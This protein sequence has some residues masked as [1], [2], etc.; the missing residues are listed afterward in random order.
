[1]QGRGWGGIDFLNA[2]YNTK[3]AKEGNKTIYRINYE[4]N[5]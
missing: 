3:T 4:K 5:R 2:V 1:M